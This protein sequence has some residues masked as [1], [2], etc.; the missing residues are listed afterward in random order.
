MFNEVYQPFLYTECYKYTDSNRL[1]HL[2]LY[3]AEY[4]PDGTEITMRYD[5]K[6]TKNNRKFDC[7]CESKK[8]DGYYYF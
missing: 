2:C 5:G 4:I 3:A 7:L 8:C 1:T 6:K